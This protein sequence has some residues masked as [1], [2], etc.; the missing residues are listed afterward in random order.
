MLEIL[1]QPEGEIEVKRFYLSGLQINVTCPECGESYLWENYLSYPDIN[2]PIDFG[3]ACPECDY[4]WTEQIILNV[5]VELV[6]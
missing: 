1:G 3:L 6:K 2:I 4:N 5:N